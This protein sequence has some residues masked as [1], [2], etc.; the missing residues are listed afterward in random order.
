MMG[1]LMNWTSF[2]GQWS[3]PKVQSRHLSGETEEYHN[4]TSVRIAG[5]PREIRT[6]HLPNTSL[7]R[8]H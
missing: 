8:Y 5:I 3:W 4:N 1:T 2:G 6:E 7:Q